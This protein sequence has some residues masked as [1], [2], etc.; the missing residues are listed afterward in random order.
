MTSV[1]ILAA[2][3]HTLS[4]PAFIVLFTLQF[5]FNFGPN[6][7]VYVRAILVFTIERPNMFIAI[8]C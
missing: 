5:F 8:P 3:F 6:S 2:K 1:A 7:V 4:K